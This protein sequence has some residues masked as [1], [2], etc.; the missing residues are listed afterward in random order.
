MKLTRT[1]GY[2]KL[3]LLLYPFFC[4]NLKKL[5]VSDIFFDLAI[6]NDYKNLQILII[7][8]V[9]IKNTVLKLNRLISLSIGM[10]T[11]NL[12]KE[13][14][15]VNSTLSNLEIRIY[16]ENDYENYVE[17]EILKAIESI[18]IINVLMF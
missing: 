16:H 15:T 2:D 17:F 12:N 11:T 6:F 18:K 13:I 9:I 5:S 14:L 10:D 7:E 1:F 4:K 3:N 8:K